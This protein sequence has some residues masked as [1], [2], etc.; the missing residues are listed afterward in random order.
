MKWENRL[1]VNWSAKKCKFASIMFNQVWISRTHCRCLC[2][3]KCNWYFQYRYVHVVFA[4]PHFLLR[5]QE[6][7]ACVVLVEI[8]RID[9]LMYLNV[10]PTVYVKT[11]VFRLSQR[12]SHF[13]WWRCHDR[14]GNCTRF[15]GRILLT[16]RL[17]NNVTKSSCYLAQWRGDPKQRHED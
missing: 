4:I 3:A 15:D 12:K 13:F 1:I 10:H 2:F 16:A 7:W 11:T 6:S 14:N 5:V 8:S 17:T 9:G